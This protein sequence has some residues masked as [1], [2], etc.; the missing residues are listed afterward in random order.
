[1]SAP[2][3]IWVVTGQCGAY[4]D[5]Q[6]WIVCWRTTEDEAKAVVAALVKE[7][8]EFAAWIRSDAH[9]EL[10]ELGYAAR[11]DA[12]AKR[13]STMIDPNF[14]HDGGHG[15]PLRAGRRRRPCVVR[16]A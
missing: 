8:A 5:Q 10:V 4:S 2:H 3:V 6:W 1:M 13:R 9:R 7:A 14:N 15:L 11:L 12:D 16:R